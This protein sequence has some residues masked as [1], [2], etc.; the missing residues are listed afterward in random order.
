M[1]G[2]ER[3]WRGVPA[4]WSISDGLGDELDDLRHHGQ[5]QVAM[6]GQALLVFLRTAR[7]RITASTVLQRKVA[8]EL[9][10]PFAVLAEIRR[11]GVGRALVE[12]F[13]TATGQIPTAG[14]CASIAPLHC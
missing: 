6:L 12:E 11:N 2:P 13:R 10:E 14:R 8:Y 5:A 7:T 4:A 9:K 3:E 1:L